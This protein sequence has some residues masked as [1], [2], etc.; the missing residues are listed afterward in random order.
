MKISIIHTTILL[1]LVAMLH[2]SCQ[3]HYLPHEFIE[4]ES[5]LTN[6]ADVET[7][8]IGTYAVL[9]NEAY[10]RSGHFLMEYPGD[11]VAQGQASGD[12]LTRAYRYTH[13]N[14]SAHSTNFWT[15][16][17]KVIAAANK[18]IGY[19]QDDASQG[20]LQLKGENLF[21]RA[22]M[23]FNLVRI[24]GRPYPQGK[25][26]NLGVPILHEG[27]SEEEIDNISRSSVKA[28]YDFIIADLLKAADLLTENKS[29]SFASK[30]VAYALLARTYLYKEDNIN[31]IKYAN[32]VISSPRYTLLQGSDYVGYFRTVPENNKETI[33]GIRHTKVEDRGMNSIGSMYI[34]ADASGNAVGQGVTGWAEIYASIKYYDFLSKYPHDLRNSFV[35]PYTIGGVLQNNQK[36]TP[37]VPM[38]YV[39][40]Y[41]FQEDVVNLSSPVYFRLAEMYLIRAEA[42][43]KEGNV[44]DALADVNR[45]RER[46]GLKGAELHSLQNI[47]AANKTALDVVLEE[48]FLELAFEG[49]RA[50]DLFRNNRSVVRNYPG[51]H[52]LS[53]TPT[54]DVH[55]EIKP[56]DKR[57]VF[58]VPQAEINKNNNLDQNP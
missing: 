45:I 10:V 33:F 30:E 40:K 7:A 3:K 42:Y 26:E 50:Y 17:Y 36:L 55:Q 23:H 8:T 5:A 32:M 31:A 51:T 46:A 4:E 21:L 20:M 57:V 9:K 19:V 34:S 12:D 11:A 15:Q 16:S 44:G 18:V 28:V 48:R 2:Q 49:H 38:Y 1:V 37:T 25:G 39:N 35:V 47:A 22:L 56:T 24:F 29:N 13:I 27:L 52:S 58:F 53:N 43:A 14:T 54:T 41:S 6:E